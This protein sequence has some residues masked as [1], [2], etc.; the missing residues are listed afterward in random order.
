MT[1]DDYEKRVLQTL[2]WVDTVPKKKLNTH[3][4]VMIIKYGIPKFV[5]KHLVVTGGG[6][7]Q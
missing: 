5:P 6:G 4:M 1:N 7:A 2:K 3:K